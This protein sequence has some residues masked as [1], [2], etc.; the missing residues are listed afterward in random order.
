[1]HDAIRKRRAVLAETGSTLDGTD[2][3]VKPA[4]LDLMLTAVDE[5]GQPLTDDDIEEET[6]TFMFE[7]HGKRRWPSASCPICVR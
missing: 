1:M 6:S 2:Q 7:G 3:K 5:H 4:F